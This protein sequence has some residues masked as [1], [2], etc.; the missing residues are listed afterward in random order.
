M[1]EY[2]V[3]NKSKSEMLEGLETHSSYKKSLQAKL[4]KTSDISEEDLVENHPKDLLQP[5][6]SGTKGPKNSE[7]LIRLHEFRRE[8]IRE[9]Y[10]EI[11]NKNF[12]EFTS[13]NDPKYKFLN[14]QY[15]LRSKLLIKSIIWSFGIGCAFFAHRYYRRQ[16][17][18]NAM[19]WGCTTWTLSMFAIWG[20]LE[21]QPHMMAI[22][23]SQFIRDLSIR[24]QAKYKLIGNLKTEELL[25]EN[26]Y[27][28]YGI[29][30]KSTSSSNCEIS[31]FAYD[32][33]SHVLKSFDYSPLATD[34]IAKKKELSEENLYDEDFDEKEVLAQLKDDNEVIE[35]DF[36]FHKHMN[37]SEKCMADLST[38]LTNEIKDKKKINNAYQASDLSTLSE[39]KFK[40]LKHD[41]LSDKSGYT[42]NTHDLL[43]EEVLSAENYLN[44]LYNDFHSDPD[45]KN[46]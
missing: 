11:E 18:L 37:S 44:G 40:V 21:L 17:F 8:N 30:V 35:Y 43:R 6:K 28:L 32:F 20:S 34:K 46:S 41:M 45:Y 15:M 23:H 38:F 3:P 1:N 16:Q 14:V 19:R 4:K 22:F 36:S 25:N 2:Q 10:K 31:K 29:K 42:G 26:Y 39:S 33:D 5:I 24:D 7:D 9:P 13:E 27:K 12:F